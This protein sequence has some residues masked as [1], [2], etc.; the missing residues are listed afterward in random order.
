MII[1][2]AFASCPFMALDAAKLA[3]PP[4]ISRYGT[5]FG[6]SADD[7]GTSFRIRFTVLSGAGAGGIGSSFCGFSSTIFGCS[8]SSCFCKNL[9]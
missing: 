2:F 7:S 3:V 9:K 1:T 8:G 6:M 4:P 5:S